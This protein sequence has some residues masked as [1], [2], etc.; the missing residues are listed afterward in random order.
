MNQI[1][2]AFTSFVVGGPWQGVGWGGGEG[3][4]CTRLRS[5]GDTRALF[6]LQEESHCSS[7]R[8]L[9]IAEMMLQL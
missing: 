9:D 2:T 8:R 7:R 5:L 4:E 6:A 1:A 3:R